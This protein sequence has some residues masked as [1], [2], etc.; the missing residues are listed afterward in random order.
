M[1]RFIADTGKHFSTKELSDTEATV[2][3]SCAD[4]FVFYKKCLVQCSQL[5]TSLTMLQLSH[6]FQKFLR[7]YALKILQNNLPK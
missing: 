4:L 7:E 2:L 5:S 3:P 1:E 6:T